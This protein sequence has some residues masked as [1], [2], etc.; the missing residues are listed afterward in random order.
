MS[1]WDD[2]TS[3][4]A[5]KAALDEQDYST[6][7]KLLDDLCDDLDRTARRIDAK[8]AQSVLASLRKHAWFDKLHHMA[9]KFEE[10]SRDDP[11]VCI[12]LAQARIELGEIT[13]AIDGLLELKEQVESD[14]TE[15]TLN[16]IQRGRLQKELGEIVGLLGRAYKQHYLNA[17]PSKTEPRLHD[18]NKA[19]EFYGRGYR[20]NLGDY[21][22]Q[23]M[24]YAALLTQRERVQQGKQ[25]SKDAE[26]IAQEI[27]D[28]IEN[29]ENDGPVQPWDLAN[30]IESNLVL[31]K[32]PAAI[33][34][35][36]AYLDHPNTDAFQVQSTRRQLIEVWQLSDKKPPG[37]QILPMMTARFIELGAGN[38]AVD[39]DLAKAPSYEKVFGETGYQP[40]R[41]IQ[42]ALTS[43]R[44][45]ARIGPDKYDGRGTGFLFD[46]AWALDEL[47]GRPL[48]LTNAHVCSN[49]PDVQGAYPYPDSHDN[50]T[51]AFL[52]AGGADHATEYSFK[53]VLWSSK[54][55][56]LDAT[57]LELEEHPADRKPP[58]IQ[59]ATPVLN[60]AV[61]KRLNIL[62]HPRGL[63]MRISLQDNEIVSVGDKYVHYRT[64]TDPGSSGSPVFDQDWR[65]VA[66]HHAAST[67]RKANEGVLIDAILEQIKADLSNAD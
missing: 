54:P 52:D 61:D 56:E 10:Y 9:E 45:V 41:W 12:Y 65:L 50:L 29:L 44:S 47:R 33:E 17:K 19:L 21:I 46:G 25:R 58:T 31:G 7:G 67:A 22:W 63:D 36:K 6:A 37:D 1:D 40:L 15:E 32:T 42:K 39:L 48:L 4:Q 35:T 64:P 5:V 18:L 28:H 11:Q 57:L 62:G 26:V 55:S 3:P 51:A 2:K 13:G 34:A 24:N 38:A 59:T 60:E 14:L 23:G 66:L 20:E 16:P 8:A 43:A 49:D 53:R 27:L 30:K